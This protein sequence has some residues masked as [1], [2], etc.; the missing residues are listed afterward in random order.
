MTQTDQ[1]VTTEP[2]AAEPNAAPV[3]TQPTAPETAASEGP[4]NLLDVPEVG[5]SGAAPEQ[6]ETA[7]SQDAAGGGEPAG[8]PESYEFTAPEGTAFEKDSPVIAAYSEFARSLDL[9]QDQAQGGLA[10]LAEAH[11]QHQQKTVND[12]IEAQAAE[13]RNDPEIGGDNFKANQIKVAQVFATFDPSGE[14]RAQ[15]EQSGLNNNL[16]LWRFM[17]QVRGAISEGRF[18]TGDPTAQQ[19]TTGAQRM[20]NKSNMNP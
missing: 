9:P 2:T 3:E 16:H 14:L 8:A 17:A 5:A 19:T 4:T 18:E 12:W 20:F 15:L 7:T 13:T 1:P 6:S 11:A 10:K